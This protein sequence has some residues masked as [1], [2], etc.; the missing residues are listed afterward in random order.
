MS[1][2]IREATEADIPDLA[3]IHLASKLA[4][5]IGIINSVFLESKTQ[6]EYEE[7]WKCFLA[8]EDSQ[9]YIGFVDGKVIGL[10]SFGPLR[11]PPPGI[12]KIR[13]QYTSEIFAI[14]VDPEHFKQGYGKA[15]LKF[16]V[17]RLKEQKHHSLCLW[18][19]KD[20]K[21]ACGFY[22]ELGGQRIGKRVIEFGEGKLTT[23]AKEVCY[24]WRD[25]DVILKH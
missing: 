23:K 5:E 4:A 7:K 1:L 19:L 20:N 6:S 22:D 9:K 2:E 3:R 17:E 18:A 21:R 10:I 15:L 11:T 8:D 14:Y 13:P 24:G 25:I 16:A 12:S